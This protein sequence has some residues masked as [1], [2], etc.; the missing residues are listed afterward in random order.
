M[1]RGIL[2]AIF[3]EKSV[4][5]GYADSPSKKESTGGIGVSLS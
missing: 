4:R 5:G 1:K 2:K 3:G